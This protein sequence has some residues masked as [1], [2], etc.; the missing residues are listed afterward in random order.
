VLTERLSVRPPESGDE[1]AYAELFRRPPVEVWLRPPPLSPFKISEIEEMLREDIRHWEEFGFGPWALI[2]RGSGSF[3]GRGGLRMTAVAGEQ[4][5]ELAWTV[6]P[7]SQGRG[8][9]TE[10]ALAALEWARTLGIEEVIALTLP[11]N[12]ASRRV[13]EKAG[14]RAAGEVEYAG[15]THVLYRLALA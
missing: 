4:A 8:L 3:V 15:L 14:L 7:D 9:A 6:D 11:G 2:E 5:V 10:A 13:A 1:A 12:H